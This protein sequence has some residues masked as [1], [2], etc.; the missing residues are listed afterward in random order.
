MGEDTL[1]MDIR[2]VRTQIIEQLPEV[3]FLYL[4]GC[5]FNL[6]GISI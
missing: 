2:A 5:S 6:V 1:E 3:F 4:Y